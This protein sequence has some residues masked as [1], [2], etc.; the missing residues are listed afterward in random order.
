MAVYVDTA[1]NP[2]G[3][4]R[5]CH[6][7]ADSLPEL[8]AMADGIGVPR[9]WLQEPPRASWVH[10]DI[11]QS[12]RALAVKLGALE[13]DRYGPVLHCARLAG[14]QAMIDMVERLRARARG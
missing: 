13:T 8:L 14:N 11:A 10:M 12:K 2:F 5:M 7:W 9:K 4:Y 6:M 1:R 3:R